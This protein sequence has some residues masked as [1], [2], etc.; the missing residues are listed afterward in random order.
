MGSHRWGKAA[1][2]TSTLKE[3]NPLQKRKM[4]RTKKEEEMRDSIN[5]ET[6]RERERKRRKEEK[7]RRKEHINRVSIAL[8]EEGEEELGEEPRA[9]N[10]CVQHT[11]L[12]STKGHAAAKIAL[13][14]KCT[15]FF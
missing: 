13:S 8:G 11:A 14:T 3:V 2:E 1:A 4:K 15:F 7:E 6:E 10:M 5:H 9:S 12:Y